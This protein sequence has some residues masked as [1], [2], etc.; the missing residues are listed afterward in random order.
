M[1]KNYFSLV[2]VTLIGLFTFTA[3]GGGGSTNPS[4]TDLLVAKGWTITSVIDETNGNTDVTANF[5]GKTAQ[6]NSDGSYTH[7]LG[8]A[9]E[10][11]NYT[12]GGGTLSL[13]PSSGT[14]YAGSFSNVSV[15]STQLTFKVTITSTKTGNVTYAVTMQ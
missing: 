8:S 13:T 9:T 3:C 11:G 2:L 7:N 4:E 10:T 1:K 15:T 5:A 6:F 12:F 14:P